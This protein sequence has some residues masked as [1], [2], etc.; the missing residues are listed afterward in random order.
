MAATEKGLSVFWVFLGFAEGNPMFLGPALNLG[1]AGDSGEESQKDEDE[2][3]LKIAVNAARGAWVWDFLE[4]V[5]EGGQ[6]HSLSVGT[7]IHGK[8]LCLT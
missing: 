2:H 8:T 6:K 1:N 3:A 7:E 4:G 5:G